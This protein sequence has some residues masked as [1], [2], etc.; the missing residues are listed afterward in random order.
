MITRCAH[1]DDDLTALWPETGGHTL[2]REQ[3][4]V[5]TDER[6]A[7][8]A[9]LLMFHG[10]HSLAYAGSIVFATQEH[11]GRIAHRLLTF[12][13]TWCR[14]HGIRLLGHVT[15]TERCAAVCQRL[16][17]MTIPT[18]GLMEWV[19]RPQEEDRHV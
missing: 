10:G 16:G 12:V 14:T 18:F 7:L 17:A 8:L 15:I 2:N 3:V 6:G 1:H 13:A 11:Q 5:V 9:G 4:F 19:I